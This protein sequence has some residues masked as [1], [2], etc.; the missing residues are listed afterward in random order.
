MSCPPLVPVARADPGPAHA[1]LMRWMCWACRWPPGWAPVSCRRFG[2]G[3]AGKGVPAPVALPPVAILAINLVT[4]A[5]VLAWAAGVKPR[6]G[7]R[8]VARWEGGA[9]RVSRGTVTCRSNAA[10]RKRAAA[11]PRYCTETMR[12]EGWPAGAG[13]RS[14]ARRP[15]SFAPNGECGVMT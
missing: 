3:L 7:P 9:G 13:R 10:R 5:V 12:T 8:G 4:F 1:V 6:P 11:R 2:A 14:P 15:I